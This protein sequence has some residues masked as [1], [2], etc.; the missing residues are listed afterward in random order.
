MDVGNCSLIGAQLINQLL[1]A[2]YDVLLTQIAE[3]VTRRP[4]GINFFKRIMISWHL[5]AQFGVAVDCSISNVIRE[6]IEEWLIFLAVQEPFINTDVTQ[7]FKA[8]HKNG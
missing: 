1:V 3:S 6:P 8:L 7:N 5:P 4:L 2:Q